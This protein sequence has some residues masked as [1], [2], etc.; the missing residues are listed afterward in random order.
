MIFPD[1][2]KLNLI[3][4][5][6]PI[7]HK[8]P[9]L[10]FH[11]IPIPRRRRLRQRNPEQRKQQQFSALRALQQETQARNDIAQILVWNWKRRRKQ[12]WPHRETARYTWQQ[13]VEQTPLFRGRGCQIPWSKQ[14]RVR[15]SPRHAC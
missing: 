7:Y 14:M 13:T 15:F 6:F 3:L 12:Q 2:I 8:L 1:F 11:Q 5:L 9:N 4:I 10:V